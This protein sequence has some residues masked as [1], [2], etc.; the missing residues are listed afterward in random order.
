MGDIKELLETFERFKEHAKRAENAFVELTPWVIGLDAVIVAAVLSVL[1]HLQAQPL[2]FKLFPGIGLFL[3]T[4]SFLAGIYCKKVELALKNKLTDDARLQHLIEVAK[5]TGE[6]GS[7]AQWSKEW[8]IVA[9]ELAGL[10]DK[11]SKA[12]ETCFNCFF[13]GVGFLAFG[14]LGVL[15]RPELHQLREYVSAPCCHRCPLL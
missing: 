4:V 14:V 11:F 10:Q 2:K 6:V 13:A 9:K 1:A 5:G 12:N 15:F 3:L 8:A 7:L